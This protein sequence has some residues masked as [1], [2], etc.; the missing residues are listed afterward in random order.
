M[1]GLYL[2]HK[3]IRGLHTTQGGGVLISYCIEITRHL[4]DRSGMKGHART[5]GF[6]KYI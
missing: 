2:E 4:M 6:M 5:N 1:N 3:Y